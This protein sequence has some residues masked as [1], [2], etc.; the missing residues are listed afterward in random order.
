MLL[1]VRNTPIPDIGLSPV[2]RLYSRRTSTPMLATVELLYPVAPSY[3]RLQRRLR[4]RMTDQK[5]YYDRGTRAL[6]ELSVNDE[7]Y[8]QPIPGVSERWKK[9]VVT[10]KVGERSY[11]ISSKGKII[12]RNRVQL[13]RH[14][15]CEGEPAAK[16]LTPY[17]E[18]TTTEAAKTTRSGR[19]YGVFGDTEPAELEK[20]KDVIGLLFLGVAE[21]YN[22]E[23]DKIRFN[24]RIRETWRIDGAAERL[25]PKKASPNLPPFPVWIRNQATNAADIRGAKKFCF[26]PE[27]KTGQPYLFLTHSYQIPHGNRMDLLLDASSIVLPWRESWRRRLN[28]FVRRA[29]KGRCDAMQG[30]DEKENEEDGVQIRRAQKLQNTPGHYASTY[31]HN[32]P[33]SDDPWR[34]VQAQ[35]TAPEVRQAFRPAKFYQIQPVGT[36]STQRGYQAS[37]PHYT[38]Y[39]PYIGYQDALKH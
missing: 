2:Q 1:E 18:V 8:I 25:L 37:S 19:A 15:I 24:V 28:K 38:Y 21:S 26:C 30:P 5:Q 14:Q 12:K 4:K 32:R 16:H 13:K 7:D 29:A 17:G 10:A 23:D 20:G 31:H 27:I 33:I 36:S 9:G 6:P 3:E 11:E 34:Y 39:N 35:P 22:P